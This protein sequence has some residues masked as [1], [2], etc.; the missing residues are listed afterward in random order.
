MVC[1]VFF[2]MG[3]PSGF[4]HFKLCAHTN[5]TCVHS[6]L[7][8]LGLQKCREEGDLKEEHINTS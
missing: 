2:I 8:G 4:D 6:A 3:L 1:A 5:E 7:K